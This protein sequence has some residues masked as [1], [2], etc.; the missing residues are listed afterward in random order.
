MASKI[1][2]TDGKWLVTTPRGSIKAAKIVF[3]SNGYTAGIAP[4]YA[5]K[6]VPC[7]GICARI[8]GPNGSPLPYLLNSYVI[9]NGPKTY[10]YLISR[11][12]GSVIIG[13][14]RSTFFHDKKTWYDT[15]N[16]DELIEPARNYFDGF[17]QKSFRGWENTGAV[18]ERV[19]T[20][21][22]SPTLFPLVY[23][24]F[25]AFFLF[26]QGFLLPSGRASMQVPVIRYDLIRDTARFIYLQL[27]QDR[28]YAAVNM[29]KFFFFNCGQ[30]ILTK[31]KSSHGLYIR[32]PPSYWRCPQYRC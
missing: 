16:D 10:D 20:G 13:G 18:T 4:E 25:F 15:T 17:M 2:P 23:F 21:S 22:R 7:R 19:W 29:K 12:D 8:T 31:K 28:V 3:A 6:I 26:S 1:D 5:R 24:L 9:R 11:P 27:R 14:A 30:K 32:L